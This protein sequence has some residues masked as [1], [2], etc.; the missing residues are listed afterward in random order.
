MI[1]IIDTNVIVSAALRDRDPEAIILFASETPDV[2]WI[3]SPEI[4]AEY[5]SVLARPKFGLTSDILSRWSDVFTRH[6]ELHGPAAPSLFPR[7]PKDSIFLAC[8]RSIAADFLITGDRD[9]DD[10]DVARRL[11]RTII[12]SVS[13][14]KRLVCDRYGQR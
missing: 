4:V 13:L 2:R 1:L 3:A 11:D 7:D 14:F 6:V 8:A 5:R 12:I 9:F 10:P